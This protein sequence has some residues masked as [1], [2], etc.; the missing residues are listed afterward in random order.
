MT[1]KAPN[2]DPNNVEPYYMVWCS[3]ETGLNDGSDADTGDLQGATI[4]TSTWTLPA[5]ITRDSDNINAVTIKGVVYG[6]ATVATIWLSG[7]TKNVD[8][9][10]TNRITTSDGRTLDASMVIPVREN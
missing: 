9:V 5:G 1:Y 8:Y 2:K 6:N 10:L 3:L 7:G 4:L